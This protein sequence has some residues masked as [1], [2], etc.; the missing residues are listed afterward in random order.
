MKMLIGGAQTDSEDKKTLNVVNPATEEIIDTIPVATEGDVKRCIDI[1]LEGKR[2]WRWTPLHE[3]SKLIYKYADALE[4]HRDELGELLC[5]ELGR[6]IADSEGEI[7]YAISL[8]KNFVERARHLYGN[9]LPYNESGQDTNLIFTKK[10]PLGIVATIIPFNYPVALLAFK[11]APALI[12]GNAVVV[13]PASSTPL[14]CLR[15]VEIALEAGIPPQVMQS[16]TGGGSTVGRWISRNPDINA[17]SCT[18]GTEVGIDILKNAAATM[19]RVFVELGG[20]DAL[21]ICS[22]ADLDL[23]VEEAIVGRLTNNGQICSG[24]KRY[25]V[26]NLV[27]GKFAA[28]L[29]ERLK[30]VRIGDPMSRDTEVGCLATAGYAAEVIRQ[31]DLTVAQGAKLLYGGKAIKAAFVEPAVLMDVTE[32]MDVGRNM[33]IFGPVF[34]IMGFDDVN[35]AIR[36]ANNCKYG[37]QGG[38]ITE[39]QSL[40]LYVAERLEC[41][42]TVVNGTGHWRHMD[43]AFG[44]YKMSGMG[45]EGVSETLEEMCQTKTYVMKNI[46]KSY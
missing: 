45:R 46:L 11:M 21:I 3:R 44:G 38:V 36:I 43:H 13:K 15:T 5:S 6:P 32:Q 4:E 24:S 26:H 29:V 10:E 19:K 25:L 18:G 31:I 14:S 30:K 7:D 9:V 17:I 40:G 34:S 42:T 23:A 33:E 20:N 16:V 41:G 22:D 39:N 1:A 27:K 35:E 8:I 37:L 12:M 28:K 2:I